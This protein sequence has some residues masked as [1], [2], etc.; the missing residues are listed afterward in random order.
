M[1]LGDRVKDWQV[2]GISQAGGAVAVGGGMFV[3]DF[4]SPTVGA[5]ARFSFVGGGI[6]AGGNA[7]GTTLPLEYGSIGPWSSIKPEEPFSF[8]DLNQAWGRVSSAGFGMGV[9]FGVV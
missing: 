4:Y 6:G 3:F 1:S 5:S 9:T 8:W 7:S 2:C